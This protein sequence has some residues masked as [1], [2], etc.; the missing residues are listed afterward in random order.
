LPADALDSMASPEP[1]PERRLLAQSAWRTVAAA[2][3]ALPERQREAFVLCHVHDASP[4]EAAE[5]LGM[6]P[7]TLRVHLF[8]ALRKLRAVLGAP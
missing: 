8:R 1:S 6:N 2:V 3:H 5:A 4:G 7:A